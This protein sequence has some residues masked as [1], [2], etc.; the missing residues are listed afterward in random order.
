MKNI[1]YV[2]AVLLIAA[3]AIGVVLYK[4]S[5]MLFHLLL[6]VA[7]IAIVVNMY[8]HKRIDK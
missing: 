7:V 1:L 2:V 3:W 8:K 4:I 5:S 6:L